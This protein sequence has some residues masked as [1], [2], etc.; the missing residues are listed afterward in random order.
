[1]AVHLHQKRSFDYDARGSY[2]SGTEVVE[3]RRDRRTSSGI[4]RLAAVGAAGAGLATLFNRRRSKSQDRRHDQSVVGSESYDSYGSYLSDEK[5]D[6]A[7]PGIGHR[8]LQIGAIGG[9]VAAARRFFG[10]RRR[11]D[12]SDV[13][14]YRPPLGGDQPVTADSATRI[15]EGRRPI[16][17]MATGAI[18]P[19]HATPPRHPFAQP[20]MTPHHQR[21]TSSL[22]YDD[23]SSASPSRRSDRHTF[24][25]T[26]ATAGALAALRQMFKGRRQRK[27]DRRV[28]EMRQQ[29]LAQERLARAN[30]QGRYT[31][32][33]F[34]PRRQHGRLGSE[35]S[36]TSYS[37]SLLDDPEH[38]RRHG[39]VHDGVSPAVPA[40]VGAAAASALSDRDRIRPVGA[41][42]VVPG[43]PTVPITDV[44]PVP[45]THRD[46]SVSSVSHVESNRP[47]RNEAAAGLAGAAVGAAA[48]NQSRRRRASN[49]NTDSMGSAPVSV[50]VKMHNDGRHVTLRRLTEEEAAAQREARRLQKDRDRRAA[51]RS[52]SGR[53]RRNSSLSSSDAGGPSGWRRTEDRERRQAE[54]M[55]A[56]QQQAAGIAPVPPPP[57]P[58][59]STHI[60]PGYNM[61]PPPPGPPPG[62]S[63]YTMPAAA[64]RPPAG[65]SPYNVP[66]PPPIP[67]TASGVTS[68]GTVTGTEASGATEYANNRRRRRAERAQA[69]MAREA[70][71]QGGVEFT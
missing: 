23:Y 20:P 31:G 22:S 70:R 2:V 38:R 16:T 67:G 64:A 61:P 15:E 36:A 9:G 46:S 8:L 51:G 47:A 4:G 21:S 10:R 32:D 69:R 28:D 11:D 63:P 12:D 52:S 41:D 57:Q 54:Q 33:G 1:M 19:A 42:P 50:K 5:T 45:P 35:Q 65:A 59:P 37:E 18:P 68:P 48:A 6:G 56:Q 66:P 17:P 39:A 60:P 7:R 53:R 13:S 26:L 34:I 29:E 24:R 43:G 3:D 49:Q 44:P 30:S 25:N 27:E 55:A 14:V 40:G 62:Q 58:A 71:G